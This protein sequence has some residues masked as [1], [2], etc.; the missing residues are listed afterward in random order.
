MSVLIAIIVSQFFGDKVVLIV[1][2]VHLCLIVLTATTAF[3]VLVYKIK[4]TVFSI[5]SIAKK[6]LQKNLPIPLLISSRKI[7]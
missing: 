2:I 6:N 7:I 1:Q 3:D 5:S 4:V